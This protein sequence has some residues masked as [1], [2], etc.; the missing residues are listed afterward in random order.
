MIL[1]DPQDAVAVNQGTCLTCSVWMLHSASAGLHGRWLLPSMCLKAIASQTTVPS[2]CYR[3]LTFA[4]FSSPTILRYGPNCA[5]RI[6]VFLHRTVIGMQQWWCNCEGTDH[7]E[8]KVVIEACSCHSCVH[9]ITPYSVHICMLIH[10][11]IIHSSIILSF[12]LTEH[13]ILCCTFSTPGG[14]AEF[15]YH[16]WSTAANAG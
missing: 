16:S 7:N 9:V 12:V 5:R 8:S 6:C 1:L 11:H 2:P 4:R 15:P 10:I 3:C 14:V 13:N